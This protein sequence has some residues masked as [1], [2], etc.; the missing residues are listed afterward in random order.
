MGM[1]GAEPPAP[2]E[3]KPSAA[4]LWVLVA[5]GIAGA[6]AAC[7]GLGFLLFFAVASSPHGRRPGNESAAIGALRTISTAQCLFREGDKDRNGKIDYAT[8]LSQLAAPG[9]GLI[10]QVL[11]SGTKQG[12][13]F[14]MNDV[15]IAN[16]DFEWNCRASPEVPG[17]TGTR[18]FFIDQTGVIRFEETGPATSASPALR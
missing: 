4:A 2:E 9:V 10:D 1:E 6:L 3:G 14:T 17:R 13:I 11:G 15:P 8:Q 16:P 18:Y 12:Y 5:V 7:G